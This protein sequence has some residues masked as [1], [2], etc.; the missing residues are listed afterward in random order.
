MGNLLL[1]EVPAALRA[2]L[3]AGE[4]QVYGSIIRSLGTGQI[5][6]HLQEAGGLGSLLSTASSLSPISL[7]LSG[8]EIVQNEQIKSTLSQVQSAVKATQQL[9]AA[10]LGVGIAGIGISVAGF[11]VLARKIEIVRSEIANLRERIDEVGAKVD[12]LH[13]DSIANFLDELRACALGMDEGWRLSEAGAEARWRLV[14]GEALRLL[15]RFERRS[16]ALL[17]TDSTGLLSADPLL[18]ALS[19]SNAIR[20]AALSASG[21]EEAAAFAAAEGARLIFGLTAE[22]GLAD[23]ARARVRELEVGMATKQWAES[24]KLAVNE[25]KPVAA[26]MR[27]REASAATLGAPLAELKRRGIKARDWLAAAREEGTVPVLFMPAS[28]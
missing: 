27:Q 2:G 15:V 13:Q 26:K 4:Y 17:A 23:L 10:S 1:R 25:L 12:A 9:T 24:H 21:E 20:V 7:L 11:A 19:L 18:D 16:R 28:A 8:A 14:A 22:L 5:V 6:G 3:G